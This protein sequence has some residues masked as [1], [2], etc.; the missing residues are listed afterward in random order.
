[1]EVDELLRPGPGDVIAATRRAAVERGLRLEASEPAAIVRIT[2]GW[3]AA[4]DRLLDRA[5]RED[6]AGLLLRPSIVAELIADRLNEAGESAGH[7]A[8]QL[9]RIQPC[10][11]AL[12][13]EAGVKVTR[14]VV[15]GWGLPTIDGNGG[16]GFAEP[17]RRVL[18]DRAPADPGMI[19]SVAAEL[20]VQADPVRGV[21]LLI[22]AGLRAAALALLA[23]LR[24]GDVDRFDVDELRAL[25]GAFDQSQITTAPRVLIA[26]AQLCAGAA[27]F[28]ER[29]SLLDRADVAA[30]DPAV[31][32]ELR[33]ERLIDL[34]REGDVEPIYSLAPALLRELSAGETRTRARTLFALGLA[35][36]FERT[37]TSLHAAESA[38]R[39]AAVL[40]DV[41]GDDNNRA[42]V[43]VTL[44]YHV[45]FA[46]RHLETAIHALDQ[47]ESLMVGR[48][49]Q[50]TAFLSFRSEVLRAAGHAEAARADVEEGWSAGIALHDSRGAAYA[51][52]SAVLLA[53]DSGDT[54]GAH[55]WITRALANRSDWFEHPA[56]I[57]FL[58]NAADALDRCGDIAGA[59]DLLAQAQARADTD[60]RAREVPLFT[61]G[62]LAARHGDPAEGRNLLDRCRTSPE[63]PPGE[64][65]RI[66][67][68]SALCM[69][70]SG[71]QRAAGRQ[72]ALAFDLAE[73]GGLSGE[74][75]LLETDAAHR[76]IRLAAE[77]GSDAAA[78]AIGDVGGGGWIKVLGGFAVRRHDREVV[79]PLGQPTRLVQ[80][81]AV[82]G[83]R[84]GVDEIV[85]ELWPEVDPTVGRKRLRNV[86]NRVVQ[87]Y[88][89]LV[90]REGE[91]L[92]VSSEVTIDLARFTA[93]ARSALSGSDDAIEQARGA[94][95]LATGPLLPDAPYEPAF[96]AERDSV[97]RRQLRLLDLIVDAA[98]AAGD[99]TV[100][101]ARLQEALDVDPADEARS[102]RLASILI[103]GHRRAE[104]RATL[105]RTEV[106]LA[107]LGLSPGS[108]HARLLDS[109][110]S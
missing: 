93:A 1:M 65:W 80:L 6:I 96:I 57:V 21:R 42:G 27:L 18:V 81:L 74:L 39:E 13:A 15:D 29:T 71:D 8:P 52:W 37:P 54:A 91:V 110:A 94:L 3:W 40:Y 76:L 66:E 79:I 24:P 28:N 97:Q 49:R 12:L 103:A 109:L 88:P 64:L 22:A 23:G 7:L 35:G 102:L 51:A 53:G 90:I 107:E 31:R 99:V 17:I 36:A 95:A 105:A 11:D 48:S 59:L 25:V 44:G 9:A 70:R 60:D 77:A 67:L 33:A 98:D 45:H 75:M 19:E 56:G 89:D 62:A 83:G 10:T 55:K 72:A 46:Q 87:A 106:A 85:E 68:L 38:L 43:L 2:G 34:A 69:L 101:A 100:A 32:R 104:A 20:V 16:W 30:T 73:V 63:L 50:R 26:L 86:L 84:A 92:A 78:A 14:D 4:I 47:A 82:R 108:A 58:V 61:A 41:L 5:Q